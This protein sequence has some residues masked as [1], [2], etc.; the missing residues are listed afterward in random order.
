MWRGK[1]AISS[2]IKKRIQTPVVTKSTAARAKLA[3]SRVATRRRKIRILI[4]SVVLV[5]VVSCV[6]GLSWLSFL[7]FF[8]VN[9]IVVTGNGEVKT[10]ALQSFLLEHTQKPV[11]G[12]FS[13]QNI[14]LFPKVQLENLAL[15]EFPKI[16]TLDISKDFP[17]HA[18]IVTVT[19]RVP[20]GQWCRGADEKKECYVIDNKG[21]V[22]EKKIDTIVGLIQF[23]G[24]IA[25][26]RRN[27]LRTSVAP[28]Y[29]ENVVTFLNSIIDMGLTP[30]H[31]TFQNKDAT[32]RLEPGW[33][34][35][36]AL[37]G[38]LGATAVNLKAVLDTHNVRADLG[39]M[40][41]I[42]MR[43]GDRVYKKMKEGIDSTDSTE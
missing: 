28:V 20:Y 24:G 4:A 26:S 16:D 3:H 19:E 11:M 14:L 12:L 36:V 34:L 9:T 33:D 6:G 27:V 21:F 8:A 41:Y 35:K 1:S 23:E 7:N 5:V 31:V 29:F 43:F 13:Q 42:D 38:D 2:P 10:L 25:E 37:D 39:Q 22:F 18:V 15:F 32:V 40:Q 17:K 30:V